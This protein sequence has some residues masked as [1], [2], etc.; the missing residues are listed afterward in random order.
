MWLA[1]RAEALGMGWVSLFDPAAVAD[2]LQIPEGSK[3]VAV[4]CLGH[5]DKFY[6][7]PMLVQEGWI[8]SGKLEDVLMEN[9]W[10]GEKAS[11]RII[12]NI[13]TIYRL[14]GLNYTP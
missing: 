14:T 13:L 4:L 3:P 8:R 10:D 6:H 1:A 5:V 9:G 11:R 12:A 7:E 2:L